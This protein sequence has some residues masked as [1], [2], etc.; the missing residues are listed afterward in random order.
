MTIKQKLSQYIDI[1]EEIKKLEK[2][3][4]K[5]EKETK[6]IVSDVVDSTTSG[7]PFMQTH[8]KIQGLDIE[9]IHKLDK[10]KGILNERY[11]K[12]L[13]VQL[14]IEEFIDT[15]STSRLRRI[16][17]YRYLEGFSWVKIAQLIGGKATEE[18]IK[19][20]HQRYLK[21]SLK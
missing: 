17:E 1:K 5:L 20:E 7:F 6:D 4:E 3:I 14:E 11:D 19:K 21:S 18:S 12:L 13:K 9:R 8:K 16:F 15:I 2:K 10:L